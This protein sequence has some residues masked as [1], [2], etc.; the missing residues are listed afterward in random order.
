M[1]LHLKISGILNM[2]DNLPKTKEKYVNKTN[3]SK[4]IN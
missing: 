1:Y 2:N 4:I 3:T